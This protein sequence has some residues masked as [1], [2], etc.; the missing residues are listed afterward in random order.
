M[1]S[2]VYASA[3]DPNVVAVLALDE[4]LRMPAVE[5][6][7]LKL[8]GELRLISAKEQKARDAVQAARVAQDAKDS[9][10]RKLREL[11]DRIQQLVSEHDRQKVTVENANTTEVSG[12]QLAAPIARQVIEA[13]LQ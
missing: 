2:I 7:L 5:Q 8:N 1:T 10:E 4:E 9:A 13:L 3:D 11:T 12:N 6:Q